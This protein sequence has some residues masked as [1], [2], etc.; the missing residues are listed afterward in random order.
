M[1][2][3]LPESV[4]RRLDPAQRYGLRLTLF[5]IALSLVGIPFA[6]LVIAVT[7]Q[8]EVVRFDKA[9]SAE[10]F[11]WKVRFPFLAD[12]L[13]FISHLGQPVWFWFLVG[14]TCL[15]L[16][17]RNQTKLIAFLLTS[18]I[19]GSL[20]NTAVKL[21]VNRPRPTFRD[22]DAITFQ[23]GKSFPSGHA[24][25]STIAYGAL[26]LIFLPIIP[27]KKRK[28]AFAAY[29]L[30]V[31]IIG[32]ARLGLGVHYVSDVL[33]GYT[34]GLAWLVLSTAAFEIWR[35]ERGK[36]RIRPIDKGVEPEAARDLKPTS[37]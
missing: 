33:G 28:W 19:G 37:T 7:S 9:V 12:L 25:S 3:L 31:L 5:A 17:R 4:Q 26:L 10:L 11:E 27:P 18:T 15:Y 35:E 13:N 21:S 23:T 1:K 24:M 30:L 6:W 16:F 14:I 32:M 36:R 29:V 22:P 34:L 2:R 8:G 20:V